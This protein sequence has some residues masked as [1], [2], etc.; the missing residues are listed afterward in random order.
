[1][2]KADAVIVDGVK[3]MNVAPHPIGMYRYA[4]QIVKDQDIESKEFVIHMLEMAL[5]T[6][7]QIENFEKKIQKYLPEEKDSDST[8]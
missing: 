7:Y 4:I 1:M 3:T 8:D 5:E 2:T 6:A